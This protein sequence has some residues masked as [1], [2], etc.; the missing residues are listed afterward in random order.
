[1]NLVATLTGVL[2]LTYTDWF[3]NTWPTR[4]GVR[5]VGCTCS[6]VPTLTGVDIDAAIEIFPASVVPTLTGVL[7]VVGAVPPTPPRMIFSS[8]LGVAPSSDVKGMLNSHGS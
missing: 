6:V 7:R 3:R 2:M 1:M 4:T 5:K 8:S